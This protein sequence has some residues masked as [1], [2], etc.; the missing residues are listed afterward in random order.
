[1]L[2]VAGNPVC[3]QPAKH[4]KA[5]AACQCLVRQGATVWL[6]QQCEAGTRIPLVDKF[7]RGESACGGPAV[8]PAPFPTPPWPWCDDRLFENAHIIERL[9]GPPYK[10]RPK[11]SGQFEQCPGERR[12]ESREPRANSQQP[13]PPPNASRP[14]VAAFRWPP[15]LRG[16]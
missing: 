12:V 14:A 5:D 2:R 11:T 10:A 9:P 3:A 6:V 8:P 13:K 15:P 4:S 16:G 7:T 1:M